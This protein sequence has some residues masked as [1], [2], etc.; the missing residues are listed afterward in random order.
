M[1]QSRSQ[2]GWY[3]SGSAAVVAEVE[4]PLARSAVGRTAHQVAVVPTSA[5]TGAGSSVSHHTPHMPRSE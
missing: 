4:D 3:M 1:P 5:S 2:S